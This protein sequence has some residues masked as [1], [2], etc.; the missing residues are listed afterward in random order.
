M[1]EL[2]QALRL[3]GQ[4]LATATEH[5][6]SRHACVRCGSEIFASLR[7]RQAAN[8]VSDTEPVTGSLHVAVQES[9]SKNALTVSH[10]DPR[11][12]WPNESKL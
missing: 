10:I 3:L 6:V 9:S 12:P 2:A 4:K 7:R 11:C 5:L 1:E 8:F